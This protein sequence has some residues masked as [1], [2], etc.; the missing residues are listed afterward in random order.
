EAQA[1]SIRALYGVKQRSFAQAL[2]CGGALFLGLAA[3]CAVAANWW[4]IPREWRAAIIVGV[5]SLCMI[6]ACLCA[7]RLP[8]TSKAL[9]LLASFVFGAGIFLTAQMYHQGGHWSTAF[10]WWA[11]GVLPG[12]LLLRDT[13]QTLLFQALTLVFMTG[14]DALFWDSDAAGVFLRWDV[15][16]GALLLASWLLVRA[17]KS[18]AAFNMSVILT[19]LYGFTRVMRHTDPVAALLIFWLA[20]CVCFTVFS[21]ASERDW[22][23][24]LALW[25]GLLAGGIG[26]L[27]SVP[28]VW[29]EFTYLHVVESA[30]SGAATRAFHRMEQLMAACTAA[31]TAAVMLFRLRRGSRLAAVFLVLLALRYF[32]D[33]FFGFMSKAAAFA[34]LGALC[35]ALGFWWE[36]RSAR[37]RKE[38]S[39][40]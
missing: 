25:G 20:G 28:E 29:D 36:R 34:C 40:E 33:H 39:D 6:V 1:S 8:R 21:T 32:V 5:Y 35:L 26:L 27:L 11:A 15:L 38:K 9:H 22:K 13:T 3:L 4:E 7:P 31:L 19:L 16:P 12:A 18:A 23:A 17:V 30:A 14:T 10:G 2:L 24:S 37:A